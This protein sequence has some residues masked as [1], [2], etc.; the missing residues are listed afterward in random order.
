MSL[1]RFPGRPVSW[2]FECHGALYGF[3]LSL[4]GVFVDYRFFLVDV[5]VGRTGGLECDGRDAS[6]VF[7]ALG[8]AGD[9][10]AFAALHHLSA[11]SENLVVFRH[12][13]SRMSVEVRVSVIEAGVFV[14]L[15][16]VGR[17]YIVI[18]QDHMNAID[19]GL[20]PEDG[21]Y[22]YVLI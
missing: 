19:S 1:H 14:A 12:A 17:Q 13:D 18:E 8:H 20:R 22:K 4:L 16:L 2:L 10:H 6:H 11:E 15:D 3:R 21:K 9:R 7:Q 5:H